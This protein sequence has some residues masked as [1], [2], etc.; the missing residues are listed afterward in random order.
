MRGKYERLRDQILTET[1]WCITSINENHEEFEMPLDITLTSFIGN[2][3]YYNL[4][5]HE[6]GL[7][8]SYLSIKSVIETIEAVQASI[9]FA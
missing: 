7:L 3:K 4:T 1:E 5:D 9:F 8:F 6:R 2:S